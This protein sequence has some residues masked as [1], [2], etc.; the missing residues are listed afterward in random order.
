[1]GPHATCKDSRHENWTAEVLECILGR[2][3]DVLGDRSMEIIGLEGEVI[4]GLV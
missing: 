4:S 3:I 2:W 1:M